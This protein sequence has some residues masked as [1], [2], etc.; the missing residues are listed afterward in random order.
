LA[1]VAAGN[2]IE[3]LLFNVSARDPLVLGTVAST[4]GLVAVAAAALPAWRATRIDPN[5]AFRVE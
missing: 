5:T 4:L 3:P 1:A 2:R